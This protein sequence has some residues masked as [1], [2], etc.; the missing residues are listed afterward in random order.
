MQNDSVLDVHLLD[1][2]VYISVAL[3]KFSQNSYKMKRIRL[4]KWDSEVI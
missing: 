2:S 1:S 3:L 4:A